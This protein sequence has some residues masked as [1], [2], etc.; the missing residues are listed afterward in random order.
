MDCIKSQNQCLN[1]I[2]FPGKYNQSTYNIKSFQDLHHLSLIYIPFKRKNPCSSFGYF[3]AAPTYIPALL[4]LSSKQPCKLFSI[5]FHGNACDIGQ[6]AIC[7]SREAMSYNSHYLIIEYPGYGI[8]NGYPNEL[9]FNEIAEI[10]YDFVIT[11]FNVPSH[12]VVLLGRSIGTGPACYLAGYLQSIQKPPFA[13]VL[14]SPF[15]SI[16]DATSDLLGNCISCFILNRWENHYYLVNSKDIPTTIQCPV[17]FIHADNDKII[18]IT[19]SKLLHQER[20]KLG[21]PSQLF[22]QQ[23]D[24]VYIKGHNYFDYEKDVVIPTKRFLWT[25]LQEKEQIIQNQENNKMENPKPLSKLIP[26]LIRKDLVAKYVTTPDC[27]LSKIPISSSSKTEQLWMGDDVVYEKPKTACSIYDIIGWCLCPCVFCLECSCSLSVISCQQCYY[28]VNGEKPA[29]SYQHLRPKE[30]Q[31]GSISQLMFR[32]HSFVRKINEED[33][34][35]AGPDKRLEDSPPKKPAVRKSL[36]RNNPNPEIENPIFTASQP[37]TPT[38]AIVSPFDGKDSYVK[39]EAV[40]ISR[41]MLSDSN[42]PGFS[43]TRSA[44]STSSVA[45][46]SLNIN[47]RNSASVRAANSGE[48]ADEHS[49][50]TP[51]SPSNQSSLDR[52]LI[53]DDEETSTKLEY[54]PG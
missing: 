8:T 18:N 14:Q 44:R 16:T 48:I 7:A 43:P 2:L 29:F 32:R 26:L 34:V 17:L 41:K 46:P 25:L 10:V 39:D 4:A 24:N 37:S 49:K 11:E 50:R 1:S 35:K 12:Q 45:V 23:S 20:H 6:I 38:T 33:S 21:L 3:D 40:L 42:E 31:Q 19:H 22:I 5:H 54:M 9:L 30:V 27:Y 47:K 51:C 28:L 36:T 13:V 53:K 52:E 15:S